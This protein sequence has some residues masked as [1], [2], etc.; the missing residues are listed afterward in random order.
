MNA[1]L[2][3]TKLSGRDHDWLSE[4]E[5]PKT[6][7]SRQEMN[8]KIVANSNGMKEKFY[9]N[10]VEKFQTEWK[11][12]GRIKW[13]KQMLERYYTG[14]DR[15]SGNASDDRMMMACFKLKFESP[16]V[17]GMGVPSVLETHLTLHRTYGV[18]YLPGS[19][20]KGAAAHYC[21]RYWGVEH[22]GF[23]EGGDYYNVLFGSLEQE[24]LIR[25]LDAFPTVESLRNSLAYD[26]MTPHH[27]QYNQMNVHSPAAGAAAPRDD[28]SP[29][30]IHFLTVKA[31]FHVALMC[32]RKAD[33]EWQTKA[34]KWLDIAKHVVTQAIWHEGFGGKT[35]TGYGRLS[36]DSLSILS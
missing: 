25:Y 28:D 3:L 36:R 11:S 29:V 4:T 10:L 33:K 22:E 18:P 17:I 2:E 1:Y 23:R 34:T 24:G 12:E 15:V 35:N 30:P 19:A 14:S 27:Q 13:Y 7:H 16:L 21:N 20:L 5:P 32:E 9:E 8:E 26:V 6:I 31:E